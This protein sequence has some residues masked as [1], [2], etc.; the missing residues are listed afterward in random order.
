MKKFALFTV[1]MAFIFGVNAQ[2][3]SSSN[4]DMKMR[5]TPK[6]K[7]HAVMPADKPVKKAYE[8]AGWV[9]STA[10][11]NYLLPSEYT[12]SQKGT[13]FILFPD[14]CMNNIDDKLGEVTTNCTWIHA[15]GN[16]FDP[17]SESFDR[18]FA[19]GYLPTPLCHTDE[20]DG[21]YSYRIDS[22]AIRYLYYWGERTGYNA[23]SPDT[24]R[25]YLS[26][27]NT[28]QWDAGRGTEWV[29]LHYTSDVNMDTALF[30][31]LVK[32]D[33]NIVKQ[34]KGTAITPIASNCTVID[35]VLQPQDS[36]YYWDSL[37]QTTGKTSRWFRY[38]QVEFPTT[39][40]GATEH[41]FE[42]P[43][44]AVISCI[45]KYLPG[46]DYQLGDTLRSEERL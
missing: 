15:M 29:A 12:L 8:T 25:V 44:G 17:Y 2:S 27:H 18:M 39:L 45:I 3:I 37:D 19:D 46:Y 1:A 6:E 38:S 26:Y 16:S 30:S 23:S 21:T 41:G 9:H 24:L 5:M 22:L 32:V 36:T 13:T 42:V 43:A 4:K 10:Y 33:T 40:N 35:Y 14:S 11:L 34:S 31:P 7:T 28:Y 20:Y